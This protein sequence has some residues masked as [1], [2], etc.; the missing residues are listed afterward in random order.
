VQ[1]HILDRLLDGTDS[2]DAV[3]WK[4]AHDLVA[5]QLEP[6]TNP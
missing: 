4:A 5:A 3:D 1:A 2:L 6:L